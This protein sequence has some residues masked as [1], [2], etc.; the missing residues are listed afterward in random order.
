MVNFLSRDQS[1]FMI[2]RMKRLFFLVLMLSFALCAFGANR[3]VL[4][5]THSAG[6]KHA[7]LPHAMKVAQAVGPQYGIEVT[8]TEDLSQISAENLK[9]FDALM[10]YTTGELPLDERQRAAFLDFIRSGKAFVGVHSATDTFYQWPDYGQIAGGYFDGHPWNQEVAIKIEDKKHPATA[11]L[12]E[13]I[14]IA[15]EIY[16]Y[17]DFSRDRVHVLMSL[18]TSSV[19]MTNPKIKR[20]DGDFA[21]AWTNTY[22]KGRIFYTA[23]G[24]RPE[25]WDDPRFQKHLFHGILWALGERE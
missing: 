18:D 21:L 16:Q 6:F 19:D 11:H 4:F 3:K 14:R 7:V 25:V 2:R 15:D 24:H 22:G 10:F 13:S 12:G 23:L 8:A 17:K 9:Q 1:S 20:A 5:I